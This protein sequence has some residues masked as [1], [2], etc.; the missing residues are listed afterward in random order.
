MF[1]SLKI[2]AI[3]LTIACLFFIALSMGQNAMSQTSTDKYLET[4]PI[5]ENSPYYL[6][7]FGGYNGLFT[8]TRLTESAT[9]TDFIHGS[10]IGFSFD[11]KLPKTI[12]YIQVLTEGTRMNF[13]TDEGD[14]FQSLRFTTIGLK[15]HPKKI[16]N[17]YMTIG[18]G[19]MTG[20]DIS[21]QMIMSMN[22]GYN[23]INDINKSIFVQI[24]FYSTDFQDNFVTFRFGVRLNL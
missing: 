19:I 8:G 24:G 2:K 22:L 4:T 10:S 12:S 1:S 9:G 11:Y 5:N 21:T 18:G 17:L 6:G 14:N 13:K 7:V 15:F 16:E 23:I 20:S 3:S